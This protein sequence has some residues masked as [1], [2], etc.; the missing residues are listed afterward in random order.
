[1][2]QE[3][4]RVAYDEANAELREIIGQ[5]ERLRARKDQVE[6]VLSALRPIVTDAPPAEGS[7]TDANTAEPTPY[8]AASRR[9]GDS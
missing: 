7:S 4:Y 6:L 1:M 8:L 9:V 3:T 5:F 2:T